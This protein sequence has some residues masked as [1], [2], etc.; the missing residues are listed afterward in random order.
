M[1]LA[2]CPKNTLITYTGRLVDI[3]DPQPITIFPVD[4]AVGLSRAPR[5]AGHTK[6]LYSVAQ[7]S[8]WCRQQAEIQ[9][10][11]NPQLAFKV[12]LHDAHEYLLCDI[13]TPVKQ[14]VSGYEVLAKKLQAA[15]HIRFGISI[16]KD[17]EII[18]AEIDKTALDW[19][20]QN[21]VLRKTGLPLTDKDA[22]EIF[23]D[24]FKR[25]CK[26]PHVLQ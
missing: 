22:A 1:Q 25:L 3:T 7:H 8:D 19:E 18:I 16:S 15:I 9:Y 5:F 23:I 14:L 11:N 13:P 6:Q 17:D 10:P 4:I 26:H 24:H 2:D 20:L 12:M 21:Q